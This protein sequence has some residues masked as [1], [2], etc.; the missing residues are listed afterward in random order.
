[1]QP[2]YLAFFVTLLSFFVCSTAIG[3]QLP[4]LDQ[5]SGSTV[6]I[7]SLQPSHTTPLAVGK[8]SRIT[9]EV[10]Y[11]LAAEKGRIGVFVQ[12]DEGYS[13]ATKVEDA[14][15]TQGRGR[16]RVSASILAPAGTHAV[17][18]IVALYHDEGR[19]TSITATRTFIV[20]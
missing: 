8:E 16:T 18:F 17:H 12:N 6:R 3:Q 9:A 4:S 15:I 7:L 10:E 11:V 14:R 20:K 13:V 2:R 1:M 19:S 5:S